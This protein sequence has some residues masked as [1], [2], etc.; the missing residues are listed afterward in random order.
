MLARE[1]RTA[2][3]TCEAVA[4]TAAVIVERFLTAIAWRGQDPRLQPASLAVSAEGGQRPGV[5]PLSIGAGLAAWTDIRDR[6]APALAVDLSLHL[7]RTVV[8]VWGAAPA[9]ERMAVLAG[10]ENRGTLQTRRG[11]V[12][13]SPVW[14]RR[15]PGPAPVPRGR[16]RGSG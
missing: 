1:I 13:G 10:D 8:G 14:L 3:P 16:G 15:G 6:L 9:A 7:G 12:G 2:D 4:E 5:L 11:L